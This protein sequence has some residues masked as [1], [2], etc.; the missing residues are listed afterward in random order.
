MKKLNIL[1]IV[2]IFFTACNNLND[3]KKVLK[4]EKNFYYG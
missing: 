4:N 1:L 3:A 2:F